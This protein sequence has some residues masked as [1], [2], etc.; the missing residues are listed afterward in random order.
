[1]KC[2]CELWPEVEQVLLLADFR[3]HVGVPELAR[4]TELEAPTRKRRVLDLQLDDEGR[5]ARLD[6]P[7][8]RA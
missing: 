7:L 4:H 2:T 5:Q 1:M 8:V 6:R 3:R